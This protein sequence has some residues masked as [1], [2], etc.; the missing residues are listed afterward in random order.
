MGTLKTLVFMHDF[1]CFCQC[2]GAV[3]QRGLS[4]PKKQVK[5]TNFFTKTK[6][7]QR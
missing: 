3:G 5:L 4:R 1:R 7:D 6:K 2:S